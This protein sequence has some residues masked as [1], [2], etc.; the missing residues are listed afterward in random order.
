MTCESVTV[1]V[2]STQWQKFEICVYNFS[3][4]NLLTSSHLK[5]SWL[6]VVSPL[7]VS[8]I[9]WGQISKRLI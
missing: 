4:G 2:L 1:A 6:F 3:S 9:K 8:H 5:L 7:L